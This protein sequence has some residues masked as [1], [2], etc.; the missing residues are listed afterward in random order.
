[1]RYVQI[2]NDQWF[3][4][5]QPVWKMGCCDCGLVHDVYFKIVGEE[6]HMMVVRNNRSTAAHRRNRK[7]KD[8]E[9]V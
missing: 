6:V 5:K 8:K 3:I 1:M 7:F 4:P 9:A 2:Y